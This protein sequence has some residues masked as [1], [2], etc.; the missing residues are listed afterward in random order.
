MSSAV[1]VRKKQ[2]LSGVWTLFVSSILYRDDSLSVF[3]YNSLDMHHI[4]IIICSITFL[5]YY[6]FL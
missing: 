6:K 3:K 5:T 4:H 2:S 1:V